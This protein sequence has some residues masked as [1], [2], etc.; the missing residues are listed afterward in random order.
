[1]NKPCV[2]WVYRQVIFYKYHN[3]GANSALE[4]TRDNQAWKIEFFRESDKSISK[5]W[6]WKYVTCSRNCDQSSVP[7]E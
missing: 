5:L 6:K 7:R 4:N 2:R 1:M 3:R